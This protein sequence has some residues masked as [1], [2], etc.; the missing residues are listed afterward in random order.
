MRRRF[1]VSEGDRTG[2]TY[3]S[4]T[5]GTDVATDVGTRGN[6]ATLG[7]SLRGVATPPMAGGRGK[8]GTSIG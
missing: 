7:T 2:M 1:L 6:V 8:R 5:R 4:R 3:R